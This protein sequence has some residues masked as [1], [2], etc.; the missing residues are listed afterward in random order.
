MMFLDKCTCACVCVRVYFRV[1]RV[2]A[3]ASG[4]RAMHVHYFVMSE[5]ELLFDE[6]AAVR[7]VGWFLAERSCR[8]QLRTC[9]LDA[10]ALGK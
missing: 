7:E 5:R 4:T 3:C 9:E 10:P 6:H 2:F 8:N 1:Q